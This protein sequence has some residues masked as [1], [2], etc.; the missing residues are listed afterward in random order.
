MYVSQLKSKE[1]TRLFN[2][3]TKRE[4]RAPFFRMAYIASL[5]IVGLNLKTQLDLI[6][7]WLLGVGGRKRGVAR[8][9]PLIWLPDQI[10][11]RTGCGG[12]RASDIAFSGFIAMRTPSAARERSLLS[13]DVEII[14]L[15][16]EGRRSEHCE[17][18]SSF[19]QFT[20][21]YPFDG[22]SRWGLLRGDLNEWV[23]G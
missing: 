11:K 20:R 12:Q 3:V 2:K 17:L 8:V 22:T 23:H 9:N 18:L 21:L 4:R 5:D 7:R 16:T 1:W 19:R 14:S 15:L 10:I 13:L 6:Q